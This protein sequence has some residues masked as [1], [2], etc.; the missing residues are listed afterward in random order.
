[1]AYEVF[2]AI[3]IGSIEQE[4]CIYEIGPQK[5]IRLIDRVT[6]MLPLG[7][8]TIRKGHLSYEYI[9]ALCKTLKEFQ[10]IMK[11]YKVTASK[12]YATMALREASN[13]PIVLDQIKVRTGL[14]VQIISNSEQ[15]YINYKALAIQDRSFEE[16]INTGTIIVDS[17][18]ASVQFSLF[19]K[20]SLV[21]TENIPLGAVRLLNSLRDMRFT[22]EQMKEHIRE[23]A[24][25]ELGNYRKLYLKNREVENLVGI[26]ENIPL[27]IAEAGGPKLT[28]Q[29]MPAEE[30]LEAFR[31]FR[32]TDMHTLEETVSGGREYIRLMLVTVLVF[33][34]LIER[35]GCRQVYF[36]G[37]RFCDGIAA[38]YAEK[39]KLVRLKHDFENDIVAEARNMAKRYRCNTEHAAMVEK[40][41]LSLFDATKKLNGLTKTDRMLLQIAAILHTCGKFISIK[42]G[43]EASYH[44][45]M[46][47]ELIGIS[48]AERKLIAGA[49]RYHN[50][51]F[52]YE[53][54]E[55]S[56]APVRMVKLT[57]L[58]RLANALD[59]SHRGRL[60]DIRVKVEE[61]TNTL[62]ISTGYEGDLT[63]ERLSIEERGGFFEEI[64]GLKPVL[65]QKRKI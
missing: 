61:K 20:G 29:A 17:G 53:G 21:S 11:G 26:G 7:R 12:A 44:V 50:T 37:T 35:L 25:V 49:V 38:E 32:K 30:V 27:V 62:V 31:K 24:D 9:E 51:E 52:D 54:A 8:D 10:T 56:G 1:M 63:L 15:R 3:R 14:V 64:F 5:G 22:D 55:Q 42:N 4:L 28:G 65:R 6:A 19:D 40:Y 36:P 39:Q 57:A 34:R 23:I 41:V 13:A 58:L 33:E 60:E 46:A 2:G 18:Y 45:I 48:H 16:T 43:T 47:T 59:R